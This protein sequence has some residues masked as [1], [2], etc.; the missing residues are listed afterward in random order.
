MIITDVAVRNRATVAVVAVFIVIAGLYSYLTLPREAAPDVPIPLVLV[1]TMYEGV[2]PAD[3]ETSVTMKLEKELA[4]LKGLKELRST[5]SEGFSTVIVEFQ[6]EVVIDDALQYVRDRVDLAK[7]E[8]PLDAEEPTIMELNVSEFPIMMVN[9]SGDLSPLRL[10][11]IAEELEDRI[12]ALPGV[13]GAD[14]QGALEPEIRLEVD[15]DRLA[16]YDLT[17]GELLALI[18][19]ENVNVSA[20]SLE[21]EGVRFNVRVPAE[22][23][24]AG[25]MRRLVITERGGTPIYL[26]DVAEVKP[27]YKD[28]GSYSRLNGRESITLAVRK[29]TGAN[30]IAT[31]D[32]VRAVLAEARPL[33]PASVELDIVVDIADYVRDMVADL[34]NNILS[35]LILVVGVLILFMGWRTSTIVALIIPLSMLMSFSAILA[36]GYTLNMIVLF[37]LVLALGMLVDNAIVIVENIY[38]HRQAGMGRV[39]AALAG[40]REVAWPVATSTA[41][42]VAAFSPMIFWKGMMGEFM[43]Y[44]PITVVITLA[45]SLFVALVISPT[46]CSMVG[47]G[48]IQEANPHGRFMRGYRR[49]LELAVEHRVTTVVL[50]ALLLVATGLLYARLGRGLEFFPDIDPDRGMVN[51]RFP[52]GTNLRETDRLARE[53]ERK[54]EPYRD[55]GDAEGRGDIKHVIANVGSAGGGNVFFGGG[56]SGPHVASVTLVFTDYEQRARPSAQA[57]ADIRRELRHLAGAEIKVEKEKDGPPTGAPVAVRIIGEEFRQLAEISGR[58]RRLIEDV[59]GLVNLRSDLEAARPEL[60]FRVDRRK[61]V[62]SGV[63][64]ATIGT[65]LKTA[66]FGRGVGT[67]RKFNDEYD[68]TVRL[69]LRK[70]SRVADLFSLRLPNNRG[71]SVPLG[72]LGHFEYRGGFGTINRVDQKRVVTLTGDNDE[73]FQSDTVLKEVERRLAGVLTEREKT[74]GYRIEYAGEKEEQEKT[75]AFLGKAFIVALVLI[76]LILVAQFNSFQVPFIITTTVVLSLIGVFAG[77]MFCAMPFGILMTGIGCISLAGVVV[78]NAIVLLDYTRQLQRRGLDLV[79]AAVEAGQTR[80]RPV[81]LT[82]ATT[83]LGLVPMATGVSFNFRTMELITRSQSSEWWSSM[84][85]AVI[86]GL[87]FATVL[88]LVVVPALYVWLHGAAEEVGLGGI[89]KARAGEHAGS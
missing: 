33:L 10:K 86:F 34:E 7:A 59:P 14:V 53:I 74:A 47:G 12:E 16:A 48:R 29:R 8:L 51:L 35:G 24:E 1:T 20:G 9:V 31:S 39:E 4:G 40:T 5:S 49:V 63:N 36:L 83:I 45:S 26:T 41:T 37:S 65:F 3:V 80:L 52:Q 30:I 61:A 62:L 56:S 79:S 70:R 38:R 22:F 69:P 43:K 23:A 50:A 67:Y 19:S 57:V 2:S 15:P 73:G 68:I 54:I 60:V 25:E 13:L 17:L 42:T 18:P 46:V 11:E 66:V 64:T 82:A 75:Q 85:I 89:R 6:P 77:L 55:R 76:V 81:L 72:S 44:L 28:R 87:A 21:T 71:E 78:N 84:A 58:A 32:G 27:S 88:T